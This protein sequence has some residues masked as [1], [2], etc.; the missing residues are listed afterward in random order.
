MHWFENIRMPSIVI[1]K[2]RFATPAHHKVCKGVVVDGGDVAPDD[3]GVD[4]LLVE[5]NGREAL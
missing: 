1:R 2:S 4:P 5:V 3:N